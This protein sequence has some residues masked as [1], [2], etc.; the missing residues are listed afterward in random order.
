MLTKRKQRKH[1]PMSHLK[2]PSFMSAEERASLFVDAARVW[3]HA[4]HVE[5]AGE[6]NSL[7]AHTKGR[8]TYFILENPSACDSRNVL[9]EKMF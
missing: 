2:E 1:I 9:H 3:H 7:K 6:K 8:P 5:Q 4:Q